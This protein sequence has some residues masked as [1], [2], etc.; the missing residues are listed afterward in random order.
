[1]TYSS[2]SCKVSCCTRG[3]TG[4]L[5]ANPLSGACEVSLVYVECIEWQ[6]NVLRFEVVDVKAS[7]VR[8]VQLIIV[9]YSPLY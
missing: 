3:Q 7:T 9:E 2:E 1:M 6:Q 5:I 4:D 8:H